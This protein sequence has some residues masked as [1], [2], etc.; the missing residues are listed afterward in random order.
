MLARPLPL[1]LVSLCSADRGGAVGSLAR[2]NKLTFQNTSV[3]LAEDLAT[4]Q[5]YEERLKRIQI[6]TGDSRPP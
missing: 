6:G 3:G 2:V 4:S 1:S 5:R